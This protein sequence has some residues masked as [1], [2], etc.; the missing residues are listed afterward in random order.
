VIK[1][2]QCPKWLITRRAVAI[3]DRA[4]TASGGSGYLSKSRLSILYR[5][6]RAGQFSD[7]GEMDLAVGELYKEED[8]EA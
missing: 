3:V 6:V 7:A 1:D 2:A 8:V 5:D 4:L